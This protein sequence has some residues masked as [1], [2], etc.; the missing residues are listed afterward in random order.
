MRTYFSGYRNVYLFLD[1]EPDATDFINNVVRPSLDCIVTL[2]PSG[3]ENGYML[4]QY[5]KL[6]GGEFSDAEYLLP[7][8]SDMVFFRRSTPVDWIHEGKAFILYGAWRSPQHFPPPKLMSAVMGVLQR[9]TH[10]L[11]VYIDALRSHASRL[12]VEI[13]E[14]LGGKIVFSYGGQCYDLDSARLH[15]TWLSS[16]KPLTNNPI[17]SMRIHYMLTK[18][19]LKHVKQK[20]FEYTGEDL[21]NSILDVSKFPIFSEYQAYGNIVHD[22]GSSDLGHSFISESDHKYLELAQNLPTIKCNTRADSAYAAYREIVDGK[23]AQQTNRNSVLKELRG[24]RSD[25]L[26]EEWH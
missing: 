1:D 19:G 13:L 18:E 10:D 11:N 21:R 24:S 20:I 2:V 7:L 4:Q 8:D 14:D 26:G 9:R 22:C 15:T 6:N 3:G 17:D 16:I 12:D 25:H 23:Y 5:Y